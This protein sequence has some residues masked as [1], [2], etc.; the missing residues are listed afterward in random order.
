VIELLGWINGGT[1][2]VL[3]LGLLLWGWH[4]LTS[5]VEDHAY[6]PEDDQC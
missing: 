4:E 5:D 3:V 2:L 1:L 6:R